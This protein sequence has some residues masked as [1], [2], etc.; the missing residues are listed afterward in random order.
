MTGRVVH[1]TDPPLARKRPKTIITHGDQRVDEYSWLRERSNPEVIA[2]LA[3]EK[4]Y[5]REVM[6]HTEGL[7]RRLYHE[8]LGRILETDLDVPVWLDGYYYYSRTEENKQYRIHC[9]KRGSLDGP[10]EI[11]LDENELAAGSRFLR[12]GVFEV[13]PDHRLLAYSIDTSG[14]EVFTLRVL[15][16]A[17]RR[18]LADEI[19]NTHSAAQWANDNSTLFYTTLDAAKRPY[20]LYRHVLGG[21]PRHDELLFEEPDH[22]FRITIDKTKSRR[23]LIMRL[24]SM[25]SSEVHYLEADRPEQAFRVFQPR[26][27]DVEYYLN[28]HDE[29][30]FILTNEGAPNF[31]L[32]TAPVAGPARE[33]WREFLPHREDV[34]VE[35]VEVFRDYLVIYE[36]QDGLRKIRTSDAEGKSVHYVEFDEPAYTLALGWNPE[37]DSRQLR[38]RYN[39]LVTPESV[40]DYD[41]SGRRRTLLKQYEVLGG[42]DPAQYQSERLFA[43]APDGAR[44]PVSLVYKRGL[45]RDGGNPLLL[46]GYGAYGHSIDAAFSSNRLSL[47]DRG[48]VFAIAHVR[49]GKEMGRAWYEQG[50]LLRKKNT[51]GD[52]IACAEHLIASGYTNTRRLAVYGGSAGGLLVGAVI[53]ERPDLFAAAIASV[54]F[55]DV[56]N[57]ML[58]PTIPLTVIEYGEWGNPNDKHYYDYIK[59]YAPY[60]NVAPQEYPHLLVTSGLNDSRVQYWEPAKWV[61]RLR[62][63]RTGDNR[64][65]LKTKMSAGHG[66]PSGR[67]EQLR[68]TAFQYAFLLDVFGMAVEGEKQARRK[69]EQDGP[70]GHAGSDGARRDGHGDG[71]TRPSRPAANS[72]AK[73]PHDD[74]AGGI[75]RG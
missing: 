59:S 57:T 28:H 49:G 74:S 25:T 27:P 21:D 46:Y 40:F 75:P 3:E 35:G 61:A 67:Y 45:R 1:T 47:L 70:G 31:R 10:E 16:L 63:R 5:A 4:A 69:A 50:K 62:A 23:F 9:R 60:E 55:V 19:H 14:S 12:L 44:V 6:A 37:F 24:R 38:F 36:R 13:S 73:T 66:G 15:D 11:L 42:Y 20:R 53:N 17:S 58:D 29:R 71:A 33:N 51:F 22:A 8:M 65:L 41:M 7:Q 56:L 72:R 2:Y 43:T 30:F 48:F 18:L 32:F 64:L 54:P 52:F 39:S 26:Q 34:L 68:E